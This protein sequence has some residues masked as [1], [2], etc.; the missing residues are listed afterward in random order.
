MQTELTQETETEVSAAVKHIA[1][2]PTAITDGDKGLISR[3]GDIK[4]IA[5]D[6][7]L[8]L[9]GD[10]YVELGRRRK[11][12][13]GPVDIFETKKKAAKKMLD[14]VS[15]LFKSALVDPFKDA[16][17]RLGRVIG[18]Y[19]QKQE[20]ERKAEEMRL[21]QEAAKREEE[22]RLAEAGELEKRGLS[23]EAERVI[24]EP[25]HVPTVVVP[26]TTPKLKGVSKP[27]TYYLV[28]VIDPAAFFEAAIKD[29][30]LRR[31]WI[32]NESE[33]NREAKHADGKLGFA[34]VKVLSDSK[35]RQTGR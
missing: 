17:D 29:R 20:E 4:A 21:Q 28:E 32:P 27:V 12:Y 33:L 23:D 35:P 31:F 2:M 6:A 3:A 26:S 22:E 24:S 9:A 15:N 14:S 25:V 16:E 8:V 30:T 5:D 18:S 34:G 11:H 7:G 13:A 1:M 19:Q 10:L